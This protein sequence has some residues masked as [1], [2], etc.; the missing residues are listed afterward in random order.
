MTICRWFT[1]S[2]VGTS[3]LLVRA[4]IR[5]DFIVLSSNY[6]QSTTHTVFHKSF[7]IGSCVLQ[8]MVDGYRRNQELSASLLF[9]LADGCSR[10]DYSVTSSILL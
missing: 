10:Y 4:S 3:L 2:F 5:V 8:A 7:R 9:A 1:L 6:T